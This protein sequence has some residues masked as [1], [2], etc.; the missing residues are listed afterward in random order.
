MLQSMGSQR[1]RQDLV[2]EQQ[3]SYSVTPAVLLLGK[4]KGIKGSRYMRWGI[5]RLTKPESVSRSAAFYS[6]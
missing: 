1:V 6:L 5:G 2:T 3:H 4:E